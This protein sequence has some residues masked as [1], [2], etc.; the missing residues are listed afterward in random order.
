MSHSAQYLIQ[1][2][3]KHISPYKGFRCAHGDYYGGDSC[4]GAVSKIIRRKGLINGFAAIKNQFRRC[5]HAYMEIK[6]K[7]P[8]RKKDKGNVAADCALNGLGDVASLPCEC[9]FSF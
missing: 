5:S 7:F 8:K 1:F 9:L 2:Y 4:S 3:Q 6:N